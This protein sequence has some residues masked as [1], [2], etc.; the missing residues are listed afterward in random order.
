MDLAI[1]PRCE[2][3]TLELPGMTRDEL[4]GDRHVGRV[5]AQAAALQVGVFGVN[6]SPWW[7]SKTLC[8]RRSLALQP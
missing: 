8:R 5:S 3:T 6:I 4:G 1:D 2:R 7:L